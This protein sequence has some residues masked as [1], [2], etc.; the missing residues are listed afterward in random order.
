VRSYY[1]TRQ[2]RTI[3]GNLSQQRISQLVRQ[4]LLVA[5]PDSDGRLKYDGESVDRMARERAARAARTA[6][7]GS[8][9]AAL[10]AEARD[11]FRRE[12]KAELEAELTRRAKRDELAERAV[13]ALERIA[14]WSTK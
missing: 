12:R 8:E 13:N 14:K 5:E 11:R 7:E 3:L 2:V 10:V 6:E 4:G 9:R 1:T